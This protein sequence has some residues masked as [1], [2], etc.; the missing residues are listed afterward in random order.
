VTQLWEF[1]DLRSA[2]DG[3]QAL[4]D[5]AIPTHHADGSIP[6]TE[7]TGIVFAL[8]PGG[9]FWMGGQKD[10]ATEPNY[11]PQAQ[12]DETPHQMRLRPF[13]VARHELTQGQWGRL[14]SGNTAYHH[15]SHYK[16]VQEVGSID[17]TLAHPVEQVSWDMCMTMLSHHGLDLPTEAQWEYACRAGRDTPWACPLEQLKDFAN[18]SDATVKTR[19]GVAWPHEE[20]VDG[21]LLHAPA[22]S[23][24]MNAFGMHDMHGN[25]WEWCKD[26]YISYSF[27][28]NDPDG[29]R[30]L[31]EGTGS[32]VNRGG[33]FASRASSCRSAR[34]FSSS[35]SVRTVNIGARAVRRLPI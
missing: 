2:W 19:K 5:I 34:R 11:D 31:G 7:R 32:R 35:P 29:L 16:P 15:P 21:H 28:S 1:Y 30:E 8:L 12:P 24:A 18:I 14:W 23:F 9:T 17:I 4:G 20:W 22:G 10:N 13:L 25:V 26:Y 27:S 6:I 33:D 3:Q